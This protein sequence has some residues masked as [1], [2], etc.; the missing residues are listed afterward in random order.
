M[1][2]VGHGAPDPYSHHFPPETYAPTLL[3]LLEWAK[4]ADRSGFDSFWSPSTTSSMRA[5]SARPV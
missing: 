3:D 2:E 1:P 5:T 4:V